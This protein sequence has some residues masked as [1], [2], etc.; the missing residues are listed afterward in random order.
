MK[1]KTFF[2]A[3]WVVL[4]MLLLPFRASADDNYSVLSPEQLKQM[5]DSKK[6]DFLLI[7][8]RNPGEYQEVHIPGAINLPQKEFAEYRHLLPADKAKKLIFYCNGVKCGKSKKAARMAADLGYGNI[9]VF[10]QGMPVWE[11]LNYPVVA[12]A[13][14][15]KKIATITF[16]PAELKHLLDSGESDFVLID[17]RDPN[18]F[19]EGHIPGAVNIPVDVFASRSGQLD[20]E[21]K[22]IVY[23][24][25]GGRSYMAYRKLMKLSYKDIYQ[26]IFA[27]W[28][29]AGLSVAR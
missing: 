11:E 10:A 3:M 26:A 17:V 5:I 28:R 12:G 24:N 27:D 22:I 8:A 4:L 15:S 1:T 21:K 20:K 9:L 25:S 19:D 16:S 13:D 2:P 18:E 14:Y 23:C 7:D 6:D 29:D